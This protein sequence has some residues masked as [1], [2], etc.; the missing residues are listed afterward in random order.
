M[1]TQHVLPIINKTLKMFFQTNY[2]IKNLPLFYK[3][4]FPNKLPYKKLQFY[5]SNLLFDIKL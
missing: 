2:L 3:Y 5:N 1:I 4:N